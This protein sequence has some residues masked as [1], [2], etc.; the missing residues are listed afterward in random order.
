MV[1]TSNINWTKIFTTNVGGTYTLEERLKNVLRCAGADASRNIETKMWSVK[2]GLK[3]VLE[4][5]P[6]TAQVE[7]TISKMPNNWNTMVCVGWY[8]NA[9]NTLINKNLA[10]EHLKSAILFGIQTEKIK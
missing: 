8:M 10:I 5:E 1:V 4:H 2:K 7:A 3:V 6:T 9:S